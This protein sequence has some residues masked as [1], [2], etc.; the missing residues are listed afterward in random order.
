MINFLKGLPLL[1]LLWIP[2]VHAQDRLD[3]NANSTLLYELGRSKQATNEANKKLQAFLSNSKDDVNKLSTYSEVRFNTENRIAI[4][5]EKIVSGPITVIGNLPSGWLQNQKGFT[6]IGDAGGFQNLLLSLPFREDEPIQAYK[7]NS[8]WVD[9]VASGL[10]SACKVSAQFEGHIQP[11]GRNSAAV[12]WVGQTAG[13]PKESLVGEMDLKRA[14]F[15]KRGAVYWVKR[16]L[17]FT[18]AGD[19]YFNEHPGGINIRQRSHSDLAGID[20]MD[21]YI[22]NP[23]DL[24]FVTLY[25]RQD[26]IFNKEKKVEIS[27]FLVLNSPNIKEK[28]VRINLRNILDRDFPEQHLGLSNSDKKNVYLQ[29][30]IISLKGGKQNLLNGNLVSRVEY[31][32]G[33]GNLTSFD[34]SI[35]GNSRRL[36]VD[37]S[38]Y[39]GDFRELILDKGE[40][41]VSPFS[42]E[43]CVL[44]V[45]GVKLVHKYNGKIPL[46]GKE[47][48]EWSKKR[49]APGGDQNDGYISSIDL[50]G[51]LELNR[52]IP[53]IENGSSI[54]WP[55]KSAIN[56]KTK[57][58][59]KSGLSIEDANYVDVTL[60]T[61]QNKK[62]HLWVAVNTPVEIVN[63]D[64]D[65]DGIS[66]TLGDPQNRK[67]PPDEILL[68]NQ[69]II[70]FKDALTL[71][72]PKPTKLNPKIEVASGRVNILN[73]GDGFIAGNLS[74]N[75]GAIFR[76]NQLPNA[77]FDTFNLKYSI[78]QDVLSPTQCIGNIKFNYQ[79]S[80][81]KKSLCVYSPRGE[82]SISTLDI[83][84]AQRTQ[85]DVGSLKSID[86]ELDSSALNLKGP[87]DFD[88]HISLE[89]VKLE[90]I[91]EVVENSPMLAVGPQQFRP[92]KALIQ[93]EINT[94]KDV[95][96]RTAMFELGVFP[97][98][99]LRTNPGI[100]IEPLQNKYFFVERAGIEG[101]L[102]STLIGSE[103]SSP[104]FESVTHFFLGSYLQIII[105]AGLIIFGLVIYTYRDKALKV[106]TQKLFLAKHILGPSLT[107]P[108]RKYLTITFNAVV[109]LLAL[110]PIAKY[111]AIYP[112]G[113]AGAM[114]FVLSAFLIWGAS[115]NLYAQYFPGNSRQKQISRSLLAAVIILICV[116]VYQQGFSEKLIIWTAIPWI[117]VFFNLAP[118]I[119]NRAW[120]YLSSRNR[121]VIKSAIFSLLAFVFY[122]Y[123]FLKSDTLIN[124]EYYSVG[125][126]FAVLLAQ[127][128]LMFNYGV[129]NLKVKRISHWIYG[130]GGKSYLF[131]SL[132]GLIV[133]I[134]SKIIGLEFFAQQA[135]IFAYLSLCFGIAKEG[136]LRWRESKSMD[137][138]NEKN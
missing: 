46:Y 77:L 18:S 33:A 129:R 6:W 81:T 44:S 86:I 87:A 90:S 110:G 71:K 32:N 84:G 124:N 104:L 126:F 19:W 119:C 31:K 23:K 112:G 97:I 37:L 109:L 125:C 12:K 43:V 94:Q 106:S 41:K 9:Y 78:K 53:Y 42:S 15:F 113:Y 65:I 68:F 108:V 48:E 121:Y 51:Y 3:L 27:D 79:H 91:Y 36:E 135:A 45:G 103:S 85:N 123:G 63:D 22:P 54:Y 60:H 132:V 92:I 40:F 114:L 88:F 136:I 38:N 101:V 75:S 4:D 30:L 1:L 35:G 67:S 24:N 105:L 70:S 50:L 13:Y 64:V 28:F 115:I 128:L 21:I 73:S 34:Y 57:L 20:F 122:C 55:I 96:S 2:L 8:L 102:P 17:N 58:F 5:R 26:G 14:N 52:Q 74:K 138:K 56:K 127:E 107:L 83:L 99:A 25:F 134:Y 49:G 117:G 7:Y 116:Q 89:G 47:I 120:I 137:V 80:A 93:D 66:I 100:G 16:F 82:L 39:A 95:F 111:G 29:E 62:I 118:F 61:R 76:I 10:P 98:Q 69:K 130:G 11:F 131:L 59:I 72:L 133:V